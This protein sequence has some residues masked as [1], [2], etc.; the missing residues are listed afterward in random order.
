V[1]S[2]QLSRLNS[3]N[4]SVNPEFDQDEG[5]GPS[6][7]GGLHFNTE[8]SARKNHPRRTGQLLPSRSE[9]ALRRELIRTLG[10]AEAPETHEGQRKQSSKYNH[11]IPFLE[12][13][14]PGMVQ[15]VESE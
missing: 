3:G 11:V 4:G 5:N 10:Q 13:T 15:G 6:F 7:S 1:N 14:G 2:E 8:H 9:N 12:E